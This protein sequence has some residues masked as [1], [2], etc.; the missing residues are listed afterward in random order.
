[1]PIGDPG[2][3]QNEKPSNPDKED[4]SMSHPVRASL[5]L[6]SLLALGASAPPARAEPFA[7]TC[8]DIVAC[9]NAVSALL[10]QKYV[11]DSDVKGALQSTPNVELTQK[12]AEL[13]FTAMLNV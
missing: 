6:A 4:R 8:P 5:G 2:S 3:R 12:N 9:A 10:G 13:L 1:M 7:Q 11:F